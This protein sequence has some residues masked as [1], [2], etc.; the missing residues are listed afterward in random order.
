MPGT[1]I[2]GQGSDSYD[3]SR[4]QRLFE[5]TLV[6]ALANAVKPNKKYK[7]HALSLVRAWFLEPTSR[8]NP[9]LDFAQVRMGH[10]RNFGTGRGIIET[11]DFYF[12]LDAINLL[13]DEKIIIG[14]QEWC[15]QFFNWLK[16]SPPG[17]SESS[18]KNNHGTYYYLQSAALAAFLGEF[19][20]LQQINHRAQS[21]IIASIE[22]DGGQP[23][24][25]VRT[26]SQH[27]ATFNL[28]GWVNLFTILESAGFEPW[29][30][31]AG[32]R[33]A[34]A[35]KRLSSDSQDGWKLK[36]VEPFYMPRL[37]PLSKITARLAE[38]SPVSNK[39]EA[40]PLIFHQYF[41]IAPFWQFSQAYKKR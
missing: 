1:E 36:Q 34:T 5:D 6:L 17:K 28:Q 15:A 39:K 35:I 38:Q 26:L 33:L 7:D 4:L 3:R 18:S 9:H 14:V 37:L 11:K 24:E 21:C 29:Y 20:D 41:G 16:I 27:Y 23:F 13:D 8:M 10:N 40:E 12:F 31:E 32:V 2:Y 30:S 25:F 19:D 22:K